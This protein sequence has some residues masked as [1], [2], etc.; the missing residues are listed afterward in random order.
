MNELEQIKDNTKLF[1]MQNKTSKLN[2]RDLL[3]VSYWF[4][5]FSLIFGGLILLIID[6]KFGVIEWIGYLFVIYFLGGMM[7]LVAMGIYVKGEPY[8]Y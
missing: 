6:L 5:M 8:E 3:F 4:Y 7:I 1:K 2:M